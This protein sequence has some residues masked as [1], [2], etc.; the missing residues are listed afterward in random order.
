MKGTDRYNKQVKFRCT[1]RQW[2]RIK[3]LA[4][5]SGFGSV[6]NFIRVVLLHSDSFAEQKIKEDIKKFYGGET[7]H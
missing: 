6:S 2:L 3:D 1:T 4:E 5:Q 7:Y